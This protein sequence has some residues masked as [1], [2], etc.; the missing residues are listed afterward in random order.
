MDM[1]RQILISKIYPLL[2]SNSASY[3]NLHWQNRQKPLYRPSKPLAF[4]LP[5]KGVKGFVR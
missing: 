5:S 2:L 3:F 4:I 1:F